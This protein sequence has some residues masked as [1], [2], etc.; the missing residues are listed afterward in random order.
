MKSFRSN[1]HGCK[2]LA[3][4]MIFALAGSVFACQVPVFRYA[5]ERWNS[6]QY[7]LLVLTDG[8]LG[9]SQQMALKRLEGTPELPAGAVVKI[10]DVSRSKDSLAKQLWKTYGSGSGPVMVALYPERSSVDSEQV[11]FTSSISDSDVSLVVNSPVREQIVQNL[12]EGHS[13]V[14]VLVESGNAEKDQAALKT[15]QE[16]LEKDAEWLKLPSP[17]EMEIKPEL[18]ASTKIKL[19]IQ[20]SV[21]SVKKDD[22][23]EKFLV[24]SLL[25]SESDLRGFN[26]PM[27]F[28]VFGRGRVLY[29][30]V[31]QG[32]AAD[33][34]RKASAFIVG[35]CSC[36]VKEQNP[37]FDLLLSCNWAD[38]VGET[39]I[40]EP[41]PEGDSE[42][43]LLSIP[44][45]RSKP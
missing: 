4:L 16:Q 35:P 33:T 24:D 20:F 37:G 18:L 45:G 41:I 44:T 1:N 40:S 34:I 39:F 8:P 32:I 2:V 30:V 15:L 36:Q 14:W 27:A 38:M 13:A 12:S 11:A 6:D 5:L 3:G 29:A 7:R 23:R 42:P 21:V 17:E 19:Q 9:D 22:P 26:E 28:P 31:G 25:N 43:R 10:H